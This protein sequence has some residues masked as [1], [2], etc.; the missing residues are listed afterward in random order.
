MHFPFTK[1]QRLVVPSEFQ[2]VFEK[3]QKGA[4]REFLILAR[5]NDLNRPR[6]GLTVAKKHLKKAVSRNKVKR[7]VRESF[8][9][10][11]HNLPSCDFIFI[12]KK[13]LDSLENEQFF[14]QL[15]KIW[16]RFVKIY[17]NEK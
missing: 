9:L 2:R 7:I 12:A 14:K 17:Q 1:A 15:D 10:H 8:R 6:I 11:Q 16:A 4:C 3:A 13:G 5:E